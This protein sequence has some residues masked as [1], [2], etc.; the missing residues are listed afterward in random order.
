M[1]AQ[2]LL[3]A[4]NQLMDMDIEESVIKD[5]LESID[6]SLNEKLDSF[7][8]VIDELDL[9]LAPLKTRL[10][11]QDKLRKSI[12]AIKNRQKFLKD[13]MEYIIEQLGEDKVIT[14]KHVFK[15]VKRG[16]QQ[17]KI[18]DETKIDDK[19]FKTERKLSKSEVRD[20]LK[21][22]E[23]VDGA[24]LYQPMGVNIK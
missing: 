7:A 11:K 4:R 14:D 16:G 10:E 8:W 17:A 9:E 21:A 13:Y 6:V 15:R 20:A 3:D 1:K 24:E 5:T 23:T 2:E 22:G 12:N 18:I 19:F